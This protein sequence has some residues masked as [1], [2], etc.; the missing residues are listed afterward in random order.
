MSIIIVY[1]IYM[2]TR[3]TM[4]YELDCS[5]QYEPDSVRLN[6]GSVEGHEDVYNMNINTLSWY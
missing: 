4:V 2:R 3:Q 5:V 1:N 6:P